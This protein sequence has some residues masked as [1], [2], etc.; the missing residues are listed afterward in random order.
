MLCSFFDREESVEEFLPKLQFAFNGLHGVIFQKK[1]LFIT[2]AVRAPHLL[3]FGDRGSRFLQNVADKGKA[4]PVTG[5]GGPYGCE[6]SRLPY[7]LDNQLTDDGEVVSLTRRPSFTPQED[8]WYS[9]LL[10]G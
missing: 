4:I 8:S 3:F 1:K 9:F 6:T 10:L 7:I 2:A 5:R